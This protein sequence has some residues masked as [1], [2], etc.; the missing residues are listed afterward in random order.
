ML[1]SL[2]HLSWHSC[3]N[4]ILFSKSVSSLHFFSSMSSTG[5]TSHKPRFYQSLAQRHALLTFFCISIFIFTFWWSNCNSSLL[6][7]AWVTVFAL[8]TLPLKKIISG[9]KLLYTNSVFPVLCWSHWSTISMLQSDFYVWE[10]TIC[11]TLQKKGTKDW[12]KQKG[13]KYFFK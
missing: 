2:F 11:M 1:P 4:F 6:L 7:V 13:I 8:L 9:L 12:I 10:F 5:K 3:L